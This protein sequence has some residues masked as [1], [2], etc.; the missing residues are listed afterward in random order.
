VSPAENQTWIE[1]SQAEW[2]AW[3]AAAE[4]EGQHLA[5]WVNRVCN[6]A[7]HRVDGKHPHPNPGPEELHTS[8]LQKDAER[9]WRKVAEAEQRAAEAEQATEQARAETAEATEGLRA[10][11]QVVHE[12][13]RVAARQV[14]DPYDP[15]LAA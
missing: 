2:Y 8:M 6:A 15:Q 9:A 13:G 1:M 10:L 7:A 4:R 12:A 5:E 3:S 14:A 11:K